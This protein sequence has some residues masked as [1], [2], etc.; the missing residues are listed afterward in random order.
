M[1][2][3]WEGP[4]ACSLR[5]LAGSERKRGITKPKVLL[6]L[7]GGATL[8]MHSLPVWQSGNGKR[9]KRCAEENFL[10]KKR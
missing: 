1:T 2:S 5:V 9:K 7:V 10:I 8:L 6:M 4:V 3:H